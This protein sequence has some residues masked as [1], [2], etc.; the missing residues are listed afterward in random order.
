MRWVGRLLRALLWNCFTPLLL[1]V[2]ISSWTIMLLGCNIRKPSTPSAVCSVY[3][4]KSK[5]LQWC[6]LVKFVCMCMSGWYIAGSITYLYHY[7]IFIIGVEDLELCHFPMSVN[8][9]YRTIIL[10]SFIWVQPYLLPTLHCGIDD[11][12]DLLNKCEGPILGNVFW[13]D[14]LMKFLGDCSHSDFWELYLSIVK[15]YMHGW[16]IALNLYQHTA[17]TAAAAAACNVACP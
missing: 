4:V 2:L 7:E 6:R 14:N 11:W 12:L 15:A 16:W 13:T 10:W 5:M 1:P 3:C 17:K 9:D 8:T